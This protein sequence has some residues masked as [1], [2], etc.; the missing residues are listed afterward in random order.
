MWRVLSE[1]PWEPHDDSCPIIDDAN[2]DPCV[3]V[4]SATF[5]HC[6]ATIL[7]FIFSK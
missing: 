3:N 7:C 2:L 6:K 1:L 5:L 4:L